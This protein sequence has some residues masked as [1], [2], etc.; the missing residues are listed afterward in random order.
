MSQVAAGLAGGATLG[1]LRELVES[2]IESD[3]VGPLVKAVFEVQPAGEPLPLPL[4]RDSESATTSQGE[5]GQQLPQGSVLDTVLEML[6][7]VAEQKESEIQQI[8]RLAELCVDQSAARYSL[9]PALM[10]PAALFS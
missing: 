4:T 1:H 10:P 8:C 7:V 3:D 6:Q 5:L 9:P 2:S